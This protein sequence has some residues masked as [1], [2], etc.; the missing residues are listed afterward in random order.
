M[1]VDAAGTFSETKRQVGLP[2][3]LQAGI[4]I[5]SDYATLMVEFSRGCAAAGWGSLRRHRHALGEARRTD[6][7]GLLQVSSA[8]A[9]YRLWPIVLKNSFLAA[10]QNFAAPW[11]LKQNKDVVGQQMVREI[12]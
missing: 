5:L 6:C 12:R 9:N 7:A 10:D 4:K 8:P 1:A 2:C 11:S 3:M